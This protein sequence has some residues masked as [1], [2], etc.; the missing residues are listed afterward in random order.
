MAVKCHQGGASDWTILCGDGGTQKNWCASVAKQYNLVP[1]KRVISYGWESNCG[2]G[3]RQSTTGLVI[4]ITCGLTAKKCDQLCA[5]RSLSS[6]G[7][8]F[9]FIVW[10]GTSCRASM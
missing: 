3:G 1:A 9:Y 7:K 5:Q 8:F 2:H 6:M 4:N 10:L